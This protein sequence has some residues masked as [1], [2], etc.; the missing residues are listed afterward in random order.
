MQDFFSKPKKT[1]NIYNPSLIQLKKKF[2]NPSLI[3]LEKKNL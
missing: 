1:T 2:Y 3:Q